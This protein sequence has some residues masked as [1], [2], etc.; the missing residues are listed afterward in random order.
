MSIGRPIRC[1]TTN[2]VA[3]TD[4][5]WSPRSAWWV[6]TPESR[7]PPPIATTTSA[8]AASVAPHDARTFA[9]SRTYGRAST[10]TA[11]QS[12]VPIPAPSATPA[13]TAAPDASASA[14]STANSPAATSYRVSTIGPS[15]STPKIHRRTPRSEPS[16]IPSLRN[17]TSASRSTST[18]SRTNSVGYQACETPGGVMNSAAPGGYSQAKSRYGTRPQVTMPC[19]HRPYSRTS[20]TIVLRPTRG[21]HSMT[22]STVRVA[23]Q[24][25]Y[26]LRALRSTEPRPAGRSPPARPNASA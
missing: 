17:A 15:S 22:S 18:I 24:A 3:A 10:S 26:V 23:A 16:R 6:S 2:G 12:L 13:A 5:T 9:R 7:P 19:A 11:G 14:K 4:S 20:D 25:A 21:S 1:R 8:I